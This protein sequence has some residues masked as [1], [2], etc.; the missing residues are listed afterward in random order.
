ME[1][2]DRQVRETNKRSNKCG[3]TD[4]CNTAGIG[5]GRKGYIN[6]EKNT[7]WNNRLEWRC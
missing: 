7:A 6:M 1:S 4:M 5:M 3:Q 2:I